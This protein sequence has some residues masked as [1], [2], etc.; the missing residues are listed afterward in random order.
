M[1]RVWGGGEGVLTPDPRVHQ[2]LWNVLIKVPSMQCKAS[3]ECRNEME[4][5]GRCCA[6]GSMASPVRSEMRG[7]LLLLHLH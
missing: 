4:P 2:C 7:T 6:K 5:V 1:E 3:D